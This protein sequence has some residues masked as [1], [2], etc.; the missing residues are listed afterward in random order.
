MFYVKQVFVVGVVWERGV[1][2]VG[3][4]RCVSR[5]TMVLVVNSGLVL[6]WLCFT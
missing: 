4:K 6:R 2:S 1:V 5:E 3:I